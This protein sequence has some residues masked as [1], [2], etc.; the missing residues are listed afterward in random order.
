MYGFIDAARRHFSSIDYQSFIFALALLPAYL[1]FRKAR[2]RRIFIR[3]NKRGVYQDEKLVTGWP[4]LVK[5][6]ITQKEKKG[7][8]DIQDHFLLVLEFKKDGTKEIIRR[9]IPLT[10]TQNKSEEDVLEAVKFFWKIFR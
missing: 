10:N 3:I 8:Y 7:L 4:G 2:S 9:R 6:Y 5:A 1:F